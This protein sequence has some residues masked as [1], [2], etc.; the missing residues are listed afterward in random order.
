[1]FLEVD[2][3]IPFIGLEICTLIFWAGILLLASSEGYPPA[4]R[5]DSRFR[6]YLRRAGL[7]PFAALVLVH[8][9]S[10]LDQR[11]GIAHYRTWAA[12]QIAAQK[13]PKGP[14]AK[15]LAHLQ[16]CNKVRTKAR[17]SVAKRMK[18]PKAERPSSRLTARISICCWAAELTIY[19]APFG[20]KLRRVL[21]RTT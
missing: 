2:H 19:G 4:D 10:V 1:M 15:T 7:V 6:R 21:W 5:A 18:T 14:Q 12:L 11:T 8:I 17:K 3:H 13:N 16:L 20:L 9:Q